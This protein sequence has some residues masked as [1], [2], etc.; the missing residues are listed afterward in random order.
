MISVDAK[1]KELVGN[2]K[3]GGREL[4]PQG[5][6]ERVR[7]YDF[8]IP[9]LGRATP[10]GIYDVAENTGWV[11]VGVDHDTAVLPGKDGGEYPALVVGDGAGTVSG[12]NSATGERRWWG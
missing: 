9:A 7:V 8:V 12:G 3:N 2:F 10:Y 11:N 1:K 4:R 5:D 6:P